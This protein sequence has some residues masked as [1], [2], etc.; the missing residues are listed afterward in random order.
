MERLTQLFGAGG[1]DAPT[2]SHDKLYIPAG[3][4]L[5]A[6][7]E[8][9]MPILVDYQKTGVNSQDDI[10]M[11]IYEAP[12][13]D[14][15]TLLEHFDS[16]NQVIDEIC[17]EYGAQLDVALLVLYGLGDYTDITKT[18]FNCQYQWKDG[19]HAGYMT[20]SICEELAIITWAIACRYMIDG[21]RFFNGTTRNVKYDI[22]AVEHDAPSAI[23]KFGQAIGYFESHSRLANKHGFANYTGSG[24]VPFFARGYMGMSFAFLCKGFHQIC[25]AEIRR[26]M[27]ERDPEVIYHIHFYTFYLEKAASLL[28][29][30]YTREIAPPELLT[31]IWD[32]QVENAQL[33]Y[34]FYLAV[35]LYTTKGDSNE[36]KALDAIN[37]ILG[38]TTDARMSSYITMT[39]DK[40]ESNTTSSM[41]SGVI[42]RNV[43]YVYNTK[44]KSYT[45][46]PR[47]IFNIEPQFYK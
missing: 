3:N 16:L 37:A 18:K 28:E 46:L 30:P 26:C 9:M 43:R 35:D 17:E 45:G 24:S 5:I 21:I 20:H 47:K 29:A 40:L 7:I 32:V 42:F 10:R 4:V 27:I 44:I 39:R 11:A 14:M 34:D 38:K 36:A 33:W 12:Y 25:L 1:G 23:D 22:G 41:A 31:H 13:V 19:Y 15:N 8:N 2:S 6:M